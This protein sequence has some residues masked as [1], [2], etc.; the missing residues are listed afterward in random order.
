VALFVTLSALTLGVL[1]QTIQ[2]EPNKWRAIKTTNELDATAVKPLSSPMLLT[3][4]V[5]THLRKMTLFIWR[6]IKTAAKL[7]TSA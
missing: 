3:L 1:P 2:Q 7:D 5:Q 4:P 6:T